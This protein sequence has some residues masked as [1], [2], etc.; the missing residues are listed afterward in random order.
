MNLTPSALLFFTLFALNTSNSDA[1]ANDRRSLLRS[2]T[3]EVASSSAEGGERRRL[4]KKATPPP[5]GFSI[6][7]IEDPKRIFRWDELKGVEQLRYYPSGKIATSWDPE[8]RDAASIACTGLRMGPQMEM[9]Y[10]PLPP[11]NRRPKYI[12][13]FARATPSADQDV[14]EVIQSL[15]R[16]ENE[17]SPSDQCGTAKWA[18]SFFQAK[19]PVIL[20]KMSSRMLLDTQQASTP[21][22]PDPAYTA[23]CVAVESE[24]VLA[25]YTSP[26]LD[27]PTCLSA[28]EA[29]EAVCY[30]SQSSL[31][32]VRPSDLASEPVCIDITGGDNPISLKSVETDGLNDVTFNTYISDVSLPLDTVTGQTITKLDLTSECAFDPPLPPGVKPTY[33]PTCDVFVDLSFSCK[34]GSTCGDSFSSSNLAG[35]FE[36]NGQGPA[37]Y[38]I[39]S[40][41]DDFFGASGSFDSEFNFRNGNLD[42]VNLFLCIFPKKA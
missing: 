32:D 22:V 29:A 35:S 19:H 24:C 34:E 12:D 25:C 1:A 7:C 20:S 42:N 6:S 28:C 33:A 5:V 11:S 41:T 39:T 38:T 23:A 18:E 31:V 3:Q 30:S 15:P 26:T 36:A 37:A 16:R 40:G 4:A 21:G 10:G 27:N 8:W 2:S 9:N 17:I 13:S 14:C